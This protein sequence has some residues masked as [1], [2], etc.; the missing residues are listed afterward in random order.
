MTVQ[1]TVDYINS[2]FEL[3]PNKTNLGGGGYISR[4]EMRGIYSV[5]VEKPSGKITLLNKI[6]DVSI[7]LEQPFFSDDVRVIDTV[8]YDQY[9]S[10]MSWFITFHCKYALGACITKKIIGEKYFILSEKLDE[11]ETLDYVKISFG[12][13]YDAKCVINAFKHLFEKISTD[14]SYKRPETPNDP[15]APKTETVTNDLSSNNNKSNVVDMVRSSSGTY[16]VPVVINGVLK[17]SFIFDSGASDIS[18]SPDVALTLIRTGTVKQS[19]FIGTQQYKFADGSTAT[20]N[21]F[22][23]HDIK[24]GNKL[25]KDVRAS[26][27]T[28]IDA[29]MLLGQSALGQFGKFTIDNANHTLTIE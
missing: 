29:P 4:Q 10:G 5:K 27:S 7:T 23:L 26:I 11:F 20:S 1:Q 16:E 6:Q 25:A 8:I 24:I 14:K 21:V 22:I 13:L 17:I 15:F 2:K 9:S 18:I 19:D 3:N 12:N 28:S